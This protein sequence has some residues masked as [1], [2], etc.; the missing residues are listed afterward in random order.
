MVKVLVPLWRVS[1]HQMF[2][3]PGKSAAVS[4][5][6]NLVTQAADGPYLGYSAG[7][8]TQGVIQFHLASLPVPFPGELLHLVHGEER[9]V[10]ERIVFIGVVDVDNP[11]TGLHVLV[12]GDGLAAVVVIAV[13][14][15]SFQ[16]YRF[17]RCDE[18][19]KLIVNGAAGFQQAFA[20]VAGHGG[21]VRSLIYPK[22]ALTPVIPAVRISR[23]VGVQQRAA[24]GGSAQF[25]VYAGM[26][27]PH[28]ETVERP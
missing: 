2:P 9:I 28:P 22:A 27:V 21:G 3:A 5:P 16:V 8:L 24:V 12:R 26:G 13:G 19:G 10:D 4:A 7:Q 11:H 18:Q 17:H 20:A 6:Q 23:T 15:L 1:R 25:A 14:E